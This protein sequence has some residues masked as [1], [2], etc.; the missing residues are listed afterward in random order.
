MYWL[1]ICGMVAD[2]AMFC[3]RIPTTGERLSGTTYLT[4]TQ[5][6]GQAS[7]LSIGDQTP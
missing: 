3:Q 7:M 2:R 1:W 6:P 5:S 4:D